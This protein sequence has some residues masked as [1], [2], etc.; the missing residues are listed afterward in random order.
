MHCIYVY[1]HVHVNGVEVASTILFQPL[2]L[3]K[4][5]LYYICTCCADLKTFICLFKN[6]E[7]KLS[8][9]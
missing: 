5:V 9:K 3:R 8:S 2:T 1:V 6:I 7:I 4:Y